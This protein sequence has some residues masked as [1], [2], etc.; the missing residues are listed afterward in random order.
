LTMALKPLEGEVWSEEAQK[1]ALPLFAVVSLKHWRD[2]DCDTRRVLLD[3]S[4]LPATGT[5]NRQHGDGIEWAQW[6]W[7]PITGCLHD[8][9]YCYARDIATLGNTAR[10]FQY[11]FSP[12]LKPVQ[13]NSPQN[14]RPPRGAERD[15]R[16]RNVFCGSM[17]DWWGRWVPEE[18]VHAVLGS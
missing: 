2:L 18:W 3:P 7:N 8:C 17:S 12:A 16:L 13:L 4:Q 6:S 5:F 1:R 15:Q 9:P 14:M 10:A 11:G